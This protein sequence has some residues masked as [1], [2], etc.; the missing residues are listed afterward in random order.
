MR[1]GGKPIRGGLIVARA[2]DLG[3]VE[4]RHREMYHRREAARDAERCA[5]EGDI[6]SAVED[7]MMKAG[8]R[9]Q[10]ARLDGLGLSFRWSLRRVM[11]RTFA[12][13]RG[14]DG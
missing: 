6:V 12:K 7:L 10:C 13:R 14:L 8:M 5:K 1:S 3:L 11:A 9:D 4:L 2:D